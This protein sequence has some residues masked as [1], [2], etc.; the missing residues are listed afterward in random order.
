MFNAFNLIGEVNEEINFVTKA[1]ADNL[2]ETI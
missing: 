1:L 2:L